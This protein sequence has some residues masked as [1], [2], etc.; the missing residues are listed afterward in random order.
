[1]T[2]NG[3]GEIRYLVSSHKPSPYKVRTAGHTNETKQSG[4]GDNA[5]NI[6]HKTLWLKSRSTVRHN[7]RIEPGLTKLISP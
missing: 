7:T 2:K 3:V 1:M 4:R 5:R 6:L